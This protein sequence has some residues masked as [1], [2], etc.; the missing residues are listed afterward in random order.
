[1]HVSSMRREPRH[2]PRVEAR[3]RPRGKFAAS[4]KFR[5]R[6]RARDFERLLERLDKAEAQ[7]ELAAEQS[8]AGKQ[9][10]AIGWR[11]S[12]WQWKNTAKSGRKSYRPALVIGVCFEM[13]SN[14]PKKSL[15]PFAHNETLSSWIVAAY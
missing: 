10:A 6:S 8:G 14:L 7:W 13:L 2:R 15:S 3:S 11:R 4:Q 5:A 12:H 9:G 1:M